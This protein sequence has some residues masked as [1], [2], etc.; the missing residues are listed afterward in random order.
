MELGPLSLHG[1]LTNIEKIFVTPYEPSKDG[2]MGVSFQ[3][4]FQ[5]IMNII[6]TGKEKESAELSLGALEKLSPRVSSKEIQ[7]PCHSLFIPI[8]VGISLDKSL[9][10]IEKNEEEKDLSFFSPVEE[11][12]SEKECI[13]ESQLLSSPF[14]QVFLPFPF[15]LQLTKGQWEPEET[16]GNILLEHSVIERDNPIVDRDAKGKTAL[17]TYPNSQEMILSHRKIAEDSIFK[18]YGHAQEGDI[19]ESV[20]ED[21]EK[22]FILQNICRGADNRILPTKGGKNFMEDNSKKTSED[23]RLDPHVFE[24]VQEK[25]ISEKGKVEDRIFAPVSEGGKE[26]KATPNEKTDF[27]PVRGE[28]DGEGKAHSIPKGM[29]LD[30]RH[31]P[32]LESSEKKEF[33][34]GSG[35]DHPYSQGEIGFSSLRRGPIYDLRGDKGSFTYTLFERIE[36]IIEDHYTTFNKNQINM[37][38]DLEGG[39]SLRLTLKDV[40]P[41]MLV[42]VKTGSER[43]AAFIDSGRYEIMR[44]LEEKSLPVTIFV[45]YEGG[46]REDT[47]GRERP[48]KYGNSEEVENF[49]EKIRSFI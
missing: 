46:R 27:F 1:L 9:E 13:E 36:K 28:R 16:N 29:T 7:K 47:E 3:E 6:P 23:G 49:E 40:G 20:E 41:R 26:E 37:R 2:Q 30:K 34:P 4:L 17:K 35:S 12:V 10:N 44:A 45:N 5:E 11:K 19:I 15:S 38:V 43:L 42:E 31:E 14:S 22:V 21:G 32:L 18:S 25:G 39:E 8:F 33:N 48:K 24:L